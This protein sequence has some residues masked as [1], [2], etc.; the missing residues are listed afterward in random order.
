MSCQILFACKHLSAS[1]LPSILPIGKD[2]RIISLHSSLRIAF[3][4]VTTRLKEPARR[5]LH[6]GIFLFESK[7]ACR[8]YRM[9]ISLPLELAS[10]RR[11]FRWKSLLSAVSRLGQRWHTRSQTHL[12]RR[13]QYVRMCRFVLIFF[14]ERFSLAWRSQFSKEQSGCFRSLWWSDSCC[15]WRLQHGLARYFT[16][17]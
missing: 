11:E 14:K 6:R 8:S 1:I 15:L 13:L 10:K 2:R 16:Q 12:R 9:R 5:D 7:L 17:P 3:I 4:C